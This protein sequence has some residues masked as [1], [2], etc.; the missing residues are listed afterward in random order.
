MKRR[1]INTPKSTE[2]GPEQEFNSL[3]AQCEA[4]EVY[5]KSQKHEGWKAVRRPFDDGGYSGGST[6]RPALTQ[7][8]DKSR[9]P[10]QCRESAKTGSPPLRVDRSWICLVPRGRQR[11]IC[12]CNRREPPDGSERCWKNVAVRIPG[13]EYRRD[14]SRGAS[15]GGIDGPQSPEDQP[16][17]CKLA[18]AADCLG[19]CA[20]LGIHFQS[21]ISGSTEK[22]CRDFSAKGLKSRPDSSLALIE[23]QVPRG[24]AGFRGGYP[25]LLDMAGKMEGDRGLEPRTR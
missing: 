14:H 24:S 10:G 9:F 15:V 16:N 25:G 23:T 17:P 4:C 21:G 8:R 2:E 18:P 11:N 13:A 1:A 3:H 20:S 19:L 7:C 12:F 22:A 6:D 5:I